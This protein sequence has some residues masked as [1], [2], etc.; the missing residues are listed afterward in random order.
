MRPRGRDQWLAREPKRGPLDE[1]EIP[2]G[3]TPPPEVDIEELKRQAEAAR[4]L[5]K[6]L[7]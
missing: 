6:E 7:A 4:E 1:K 2:R 5:M 3:Y